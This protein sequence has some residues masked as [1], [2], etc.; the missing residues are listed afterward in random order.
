VAQG[1]G[2]H[3]AAKA[4]GL[5]SWSSRVQGT[6]SSSSS[7]GGPQQMYVGG[8]HMMLAAGL[9]HATK[10]LQRLHVSTPGRVWHYGYTQGW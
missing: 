9:P 2:S 3:V 10:T 8:V 4:Q 5:G 7:W 6:S 1:S